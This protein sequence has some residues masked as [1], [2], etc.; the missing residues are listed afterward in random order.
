LRSLGS[1]GLPATVEVGGLRSWARATALVAVLAA[2]RISALL[3]GR[4]R[5]R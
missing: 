5:V 4:R 3:R 2:R 1:G